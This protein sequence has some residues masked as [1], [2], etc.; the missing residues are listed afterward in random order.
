MFFLSFVNFHLE[1]FSEGKRFPAGIVTTLPSGGEMME[2]GIRM[3]E[4]EWGNIFMSCCVH[5]NF[6]TAGD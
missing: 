3:V 5:S 1:K 4:E 6:S 2:A